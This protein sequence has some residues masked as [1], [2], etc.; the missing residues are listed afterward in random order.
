MGEDRRERIGGGGDRREM[1]GKRRD[2]E[3]ER[4]IKM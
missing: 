3:K 1:E 4:D 2:E